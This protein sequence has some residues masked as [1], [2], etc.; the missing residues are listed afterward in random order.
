MKEPQFLHL[1]AITRDFAE[2]MMSQ[3][4]TEAQLMGGTGITLAQITP[5]ETLA[6]ITA[7]IEIFNRAV[8]LTGDDLVHVKWAQERRL[9]RLGLIG[10]LGRTSPTL[11][12]LLENLNRYQRA[13][14]EAVVADL[15][16]LRTKG[17]YRWS[18]VV[19]IEVDSS[20]FVEAQAVQMMAG[21]RFILPRDPRP[22]RLSFAHHRASN[23]AT[24]KQYFN[25]PVAFG[26]HDNEIVFQK[27]DLELPLTTADTELFAIL[28]KHCDMV[29]DRT[30]SARTD[31]RVLVEGKI[32]DRLSTGKANIDVVARDL[33]MSSRT[34]ARRLGELDTTYQKVLSNLRR[35]LAERYFK[36]G[37]MTQAEITF[38]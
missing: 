13:I 21:L 28:Q 4:Y 29:L 32:A 10:Y 31:I 18:T 23:I 37:V 20:N 1:A 2:H 27:A 16:E 8:T 26:Q 25:C 24:F 6:P 3:G 12:D 35:A 22:V 9:R 34:L 17:V 15:S 38:L 19:P 36:D 5:A 33:G 7:T 14:S 11:G 30:P